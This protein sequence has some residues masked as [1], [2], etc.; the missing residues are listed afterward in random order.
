MAATVR[1][2]AAAIRT[3]A[4]DITDPASADGGRDSASASAWGRAGAGDPLD[5]NFVIA[6][7]SVALGASRTRL[8]RVVI[9][10]FV[11]QA[12]AVR[13]ERS[14]MSARRAARIGECLEFGP[15]FAVRIVADGEIAGYQ[16]HLFPIIVHERLRGE[17][18]RPD[19]QQPRAAASLVCFIEGSGEDLLLDSGGIAGRD[20][21]PAFHIEGVELIMCLVH[22]H[23]DLP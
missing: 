11:E 1:I 13:T 5:L 3:T 4:A 14:V 21:P 19:S 17:N 23:R 16:E 7:G 9:M 12:A 8:R 18:A 15:A 6:Q 10:N 2:T 20:L 22:G